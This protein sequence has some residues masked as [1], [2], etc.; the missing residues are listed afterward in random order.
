MNGSNS[1]NDIHFSVVVVLTTIG[2]NV[3]STVLALMTVM[4][5]LAV[6]AVI[7]VMTIMDLMTMIGILHF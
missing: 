7:T 5:F 2:S 6:M 3:S 4:A 1:Y